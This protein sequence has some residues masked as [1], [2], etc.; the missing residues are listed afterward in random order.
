MIASDAPTIH[1][2]SANCA[3]QRSCPICADLNPV[4]WMTAPDR[5]HGRTK[6]YQLLRCRSCSMVW[7]DEPPS[8]AEMG[9]HYGPDYDRTISTAAKAPDHWVGRRDELFRLK[10]CG[11]AVLDL[12]C[13]TGGF[14]STLKGP[15]W[16]LFGIEMSEEAATAARSR[17]GAEVFVGDI[18]DA[19]FPP[20]SFDAITCFNVFEHVYEPKEVL[21][22]VSE[23]LKRDGIFFTMMPNIDSAGA[24]IFKSYWYALELPRHLYHYS[25]KTLASLAQS[26][27]LRELFI[28]AQR[29]LY[30]ERSIA[31]VGDDAFRRLGLKRLPAA[32]ATEAGLAWKIVRKAFRLTLLPLITAG[33][34]L[35]GDGEM[36]YAAFRK[37]GCAIRSTACSEEDR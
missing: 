6:Q 13:S 19:P 8:N 12:G 27:G 17:C 3:G 20:Q 31:Y 32:E 1:A 36:I 21:T 23:W 2:A 15:S 7:L 33:A 4:P 24:R 5:F 18:L 16:S 29:D 37:D 26:V 28:N 9:M 35:A 11:G 30:F 34:S 10:P 25:P 22:K 14:L